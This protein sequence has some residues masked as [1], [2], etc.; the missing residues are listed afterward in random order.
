MD[1]LPKIGSR[2]STKDALSISER[3]AKAGADLACQSAS[4]IDP[5]SASNTDPLERRVRRVGRSSPSGGSVERVLKRQLSKRPSSPSRHQALEAAALYCGRTR[6]AQ[7]L[8]DHDDALARPAERLGAALEVV[9]ACRTL[10]MIAHLLQ[11]GLSHVEVRRP[12]QMIGRHLPVVTHHP[13][14]PSAHTASTIPA[15]TVVSSARTLVVRGP[16]RAPAG[17]SHRSRA[18]ERAGGASA[19]SGEPG[20]HAPPHEQRQPVTTVERCGGRSG[21]PAQRLVLRD[22]LV[23]I[24]LR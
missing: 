7:V 1:T 8:I 13:P 11:R 12:P 14:P 3:L 24:P 6:D 5:G 9:L 10:A 16:P 18:T 22:Q 17:G 2:R 15:N 20:V 23:P 4:K 21:L 19:V